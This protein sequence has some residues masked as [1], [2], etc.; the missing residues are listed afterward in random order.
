MA[1]ASET[2]STLQLAGE[3]GYTILSAQLDSAHG[4]R[5]KADKYARAARAAGRKAPLENISAARFIYVTDSVKQAIDDLRPA[6]THEM[7]FQRQRGLMK[8]IKSHLD[9][10]GVAAEDIGFDH[11]LEAGLYCIGDADTVTAQLKRFHDET[12]GFG[13]LMMVT[14]KDWATREKRARSMKLF[15]EQVAPHLRDLRA[16]REV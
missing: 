3:R 6:V 2:D 5:K 7:G 10:P 13:T 12:G 14:G 16:D 11:L 4:I 8:I 15:M 1:T 9:L